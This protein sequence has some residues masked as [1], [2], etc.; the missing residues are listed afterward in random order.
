MLSPIRPHYIMTDQYGFT[1]TAPKYIGR[2]IYRHL[3]D[4]NMYI[5]VV[6]YVVSHTAPVYIHLY[7]LMGKYA[8]NPMV[9]LYIGRAT[10]LQSHDTNTY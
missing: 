5:L 7:I 2:P 8:C 1:H 3:G 6:K 10:C 9:P 4:P